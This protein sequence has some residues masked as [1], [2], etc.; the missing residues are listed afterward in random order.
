MEICF[1]VLHYLAYEMTRECVDT[2]LDVFAGKEFH[3]AI[4]DNGSSN[5]T[6]IKLKEQY[7]DNTNVTVL[8]NKENLGFARGN[9]VGYT[10]IRE[11][12]NPKYIVVM[13]NDVLIKD[14][15]FIEKIQNLEETIGFDV[16]GPDIYNPYDSIHQNPLRM[17]PITVE[18]VKNRLRVSDYIIKHPHV[19]Y[20]R[21]FLKRYLF[22]PAPIGR[23]VEEYG[24]PHSEVVLHGAC[25]IFSS[26]YIEQRKKCFNPQ[27]FLYGEEHI[28]HHECMKRNLKMIYSPELQV[29]HYMR[30]A[31]DASFKS[32]YAKFVNKYKR[33]KESSMV[34]LKVLE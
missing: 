16:L 34:L 12:F 3:I 10:Y 2:L 13:N 20:A 33:L 30:V 21:S 18:E 14:K 5:K 1:V 25:L 6:G 19:S 32:D 29:E 23:S 24:K 9:N 15:L 17:K 4:V 7:A 26:N 31:T 8:L 22:G 27:T 28:L 11:R